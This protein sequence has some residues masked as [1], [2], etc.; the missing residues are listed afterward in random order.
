ALVAA[1]ALTP[2]ARRVALAANLVAAVRPDRL[3]REVR[4]Y[5]GGLAI[6]DT[7]ILVVGGAWLAA[8]LLGP[9]A[10][11]A[12]LPAGAGAR[13]GG[14]GPVLARLGIGA[15]LFFII[16]LVDDRYALRALPKL[17]LELAAAAIV[18]VGLGLRATVWLT[19]P[20]AAEVASILWVVA[21]VNAFNMLDHADGLAAA[22]GMVAMLALAAGQ[23][24]VGEWFVA[25]LA[26]ATAGALAG[27]LLYNFPPAKLFMGDAGSHLVGYLLATL[28]MAA[29]Y[30]V[31]ERG[32]TRLAVLVPLAVLA[33]PLFDMVCVLAS[34]V[35]RGACPVTGDAT[36]HLG[37]RML[38]RGTRPA[39]VV[40]F[41][42]GVAAATG[43]A[44]MLMYRA[45]GMRL[46]GAWCLVG[47][48]LAAH[49]LVRRPP[50][51][52]ETP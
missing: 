10:L 12:W 34:R 39:V 6:A 11:P 36:S 41:A 19:V 30:Y 37:H 2:L 17:L 22:V 27:F 14:H 32:A 5:G 25:A 24:L 50:A 15:M 20:G 3:H 21:V 38:A 45:E 49:L 29:R 48:A 28:A 13:G 18:V 52:K 51:T 4:P 43:A 1:A 42:A 35:G 40:V 31:P 33:V 44:S 7:L 47:A 16:G 8:A 9:D 26:M 23:M 46:V